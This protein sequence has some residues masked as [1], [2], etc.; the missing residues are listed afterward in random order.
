M[1][2]HEYEVAGGINQ[3]QI[4]SQ[5]VHYWH[6]ILFFL[7][8]VDMRGRFVF[9]HLTVRGGSEALRVRKFPRR[10]IPTGGR[11]RH[12]RYRRIMNTKDRFLYGK[13]ETVRSERGPRKEHISTLP[14]L[15]KKIHGKKSVIKQKDKQTR[16]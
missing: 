4:N 8:T 3:A 2:T 12:A 13:G 9:Y 14:F 1:I 5:R 6:E 10:H 16:R 7:D 15:P 11:C